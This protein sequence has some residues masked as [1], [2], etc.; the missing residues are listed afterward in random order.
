MEALDNGDIDAKDLIDNF[1]K[2]SGAKGNPE[3]YWN[4]RAVKK[5]GSDALNDT[6]KKGKPTSKAKKAKKWLEAGNPK[7]YDNPP[8]V[9]QILRAYKNKFRRSSNW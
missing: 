5:Y 6:N 2:T 8:T 4:E 7:G 3:K 1:K 9:E